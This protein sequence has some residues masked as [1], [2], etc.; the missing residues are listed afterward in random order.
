MPVIESAA[1]FK[2]SYDKAILEKHDESFILNL[3]RESVSDVLY[4][5]ADIPC[6]CTPFYVSVFESSGYFIC[7]IAGETFDYSEALLDHECCVDLECVEHE[8]KRR[9]KDGLQSKHADCV[10]EVLECI[11]VSH[12]SNVFNY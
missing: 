11:K 10:K 1:M 12:E 4:F 6:S 7:S 3:L 8:L 9:I 5:L 2:V